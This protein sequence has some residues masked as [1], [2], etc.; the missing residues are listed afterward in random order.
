MQKNWYAVYTKPHCERKVS[1]LLSKKKIENFCPLNFKEYRSL[2]RKSI[3]Y[4]PVFNSYVFVKCTLEDTITLSKQIN[5]V[6]SLLYWKGNPATIN[7]AEINAIREF[8][9][10]QHDIKLEKL[11]PKI[12]AIENKNVS[13]LLDGQIV[14]VKNKPVKV[15]LPSLGYTMVAN[16]KETGILGSPLANQQ[17]SILAN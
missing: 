7:E 12:E 16:V 6:I 10:E 3:L 14:R 17:L 1:L 5:G 15:D 11:N 9:K 13:Y 4:E 2:F 8:T